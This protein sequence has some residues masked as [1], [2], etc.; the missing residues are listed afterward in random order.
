[1]RDLETGEAEEEGEEEETYV[2]N[3]F[4]SHRD[5]S[6]CSLLRSEVELVG[7]KGQYLGS[8]SAQ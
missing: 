5:D 7:K 1:V 8:Y 3:S 4:A 6:H 2:S